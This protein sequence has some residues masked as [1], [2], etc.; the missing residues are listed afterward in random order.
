MCQ[1]R[2]TE[3][4]AELTELAA[5]LSEFS[6]PKQ[7]S[8]NSLLPVSYSNSLGGSQDSPLKQF[9]EGL[10]KWFPRGHP[11]KVLLFGA[12]APPP[13]SPLA[14]PRDGPLLWAFQCLKMF[15]ALP[16]PRKYVQ[17]IV[18]CSG[19]LRYYAVSTISSETSIF[20]MQLHLPCF[21]SCELFSI[22]VCS[23]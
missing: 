18:D 20:S 8:R 5:E 19:I 11:R 23:F 15:S 10:Q 2:L 3:F 4:F 6:P 1:S 7:Y 22:C 13:P 9:S 14:L 16:Y 21:C 12:F 17:S